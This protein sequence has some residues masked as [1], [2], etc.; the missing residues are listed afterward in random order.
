MFEADDAGN[1]MDE[2]NL[3]LIRSPISLTLFFLSEVS[4]AAWI[5]LNLIAD[6]SEKKHNAIV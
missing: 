3:T 4:A 1:L 5:M 2:T 6:P